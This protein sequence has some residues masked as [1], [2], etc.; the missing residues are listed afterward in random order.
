MS[1]A[2][3]GRGADLDALAAAF[4]GPLGGVQPPAGLPD[5]TL[6]T[7]LANEFFAALPGQSLPMSAGPSLP[8]FGAS[9]VEVGGTLA[10]HAAAAATSPL[11]T[12]GVTAAFGASPS[13]SPFDSSAIDQRVFDSLI[14]AAIPPPA[15]AVSGPSLP[16]FGASPTEA[17]G[18]AS[19]QS[20]PTPDFVSAPGIGAP[21]TAAPVSARDVSVIDLKGID[22]LTRTPDPLLPSSVE[23]EPSLSGF[24]ASKGI[25]ARPETS[26]SSNSLPGVSHSSP[27]QPP[28][29]T[30][31]PQILDNHTGI[32]TPR[33]GGTVSGYDRIAIPFE[34]ELK[35]LL[36]PLA[37]EPCVAGANSASSLYFST[38]SRRPQVASVS[39]VAARRL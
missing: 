23:A 11:P 5:V 28:P 16:G 8:G 19:G 4:R 32:E 34:A 14:G 7:K 21:V 13:V 26:R 3:L 10:P 30:P 15:S 35:S 37:A 18:Q 25:P 36:A 6:L 17:A 20:T 12:S 33:S 29:A 39:Q 31:P 38:N 1:T 22:T 24:G 27:P 2:D 9:P